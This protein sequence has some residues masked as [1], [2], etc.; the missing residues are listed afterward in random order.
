MPI[1]RA[2]LFDDVTLEKIA[3][4][5]IHQEQLEQVLDDFVVVSN[6][7]GRRAEY[8][9]IGRDWGGACLAIPVEPTYETDLWRP[10]TAWYYKGSE[11]ALL[12]RLTR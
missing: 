9:V 4:H 7:R 12:D 1:I 8:L 5:H 6:R 11:G 10:V 3:Y 2:F